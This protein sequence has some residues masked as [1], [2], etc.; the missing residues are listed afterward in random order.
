MFEQKE[1]PWIGQGQ[2]AP[3][4]TPIITSH[5]KEEASMERQQSGQKGE[6]QLDTDGINDHWSPACIHM[7][8]SDDDDQLMA[9]GAR[10]H[11]HD[12]AHEAGDLGD[13]FTGRILGFSAKLSRGLHEGSCLDRRV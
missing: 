2:G 8:T 9:S 7:A 13:F 3:P 12:S 6:E 5:N 11:T 10:T 4:C 1:V